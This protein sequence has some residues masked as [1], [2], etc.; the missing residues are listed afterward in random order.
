MAGSV[1]VGAAFGIAVVAGAGFRASVPVLQIQGLAII[2]SF[3]VALFGSTLL[4]LRLF[5]PLLMANGLAVVVAT[6]LSLALIPGLGA[7]G[8]AIAP[9]AA[10]ACLAAAYAVSLWRAR[11]ALR[12]SVGLLPRVALATGISLAVAYV[13]PISSAAALFV[14]GGVYV[15][16]LGALRAI[17]FEVINALLRRSPP[18]E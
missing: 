14:F 7:K 13:L 17:P 10:E 9:T 18:P 1:L 5:R 2:T 6:G 12:V 11:P 16:C 3:M 4:S 15:A 8:A